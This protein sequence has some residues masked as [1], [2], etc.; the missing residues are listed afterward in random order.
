MQN[1]WNNYDQ[2]G[3][4]PLQKVIVDQVDMYLKKKVPATRRALS[5]ARRAEE[6]SSDMR[7]MQAAF[8]MGVKSEYSDLD[9][10]LQLEV[11]VRAVFSQPDSLCDEVVVEPGSSSQRQLQPRGKNTLDY[12]TLV[13]IVTC[14]VVP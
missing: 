7:K 8:E 12:L 4:D 10:E 3:T 14:V 5:P 6:A 1:T 9:V 11:S 13:R 2:Q